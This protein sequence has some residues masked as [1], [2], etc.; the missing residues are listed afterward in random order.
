MGGAGIGGHA[1]RSPARYVACILKC[2]ERLAARSPGLQDPLSVEPL[3]GGKAGP[4]LPRW[5]RIPMLAEAFD[6]YRSLQTVRDAVGAIYDEYKTDIYIT[7]RGGL[8][9]AFHPSKL[10]RAKTLPPPADL[11][12]R[13]SNSTMPRAGALTAVVNHQQLLECYAAAAEGDAATPHA[14]TRYRYTY[15]VTDQTQRRFTRQPWGG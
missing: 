5:R 1:R 14:T 11:F 13:K 15:F 6:A 8:V 3:P 9:A 2:H 10:P 4:L 7:V 12:D